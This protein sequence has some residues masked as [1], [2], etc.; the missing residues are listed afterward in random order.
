[1]GLQA[2]STIRVSIVMLDRLAKRAAKTVKKRF[3]LGATLTRFDPKTL[4]P[5]LPQTAF[6]QGLQHPQ[7]RPKSLRFQKK[8]GPLWHHNKRTGNR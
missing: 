4:T 2:L 3:F 1:M 6:Y 7:N 5:L 8:K